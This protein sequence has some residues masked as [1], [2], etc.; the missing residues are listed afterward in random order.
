MIQQ[1][2]WMTPRLPA[3]TY[4]GTVVPFRKIL[5]FQ[6]RSRFVGDIRVN[7]VQTV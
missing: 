3:W 6:K 7:V 2:L 5:T 1:N 4:E